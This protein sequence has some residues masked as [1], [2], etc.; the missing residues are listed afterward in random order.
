MH[1]ADPRW[2]KIARVVDAARK[3]ENAA[4]VSAEKVTT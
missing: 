2:R 3:N 1:G 4:P